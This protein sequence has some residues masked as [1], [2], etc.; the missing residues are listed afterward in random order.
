MRGVLPDG[1]E[2]AFIPNARD[3]IGGIRASGGQEAGDENQGKLEV[4]HGYSVDWV[5]FG[6]HNA[7]NQFDLRV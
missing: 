2:R 1:R 3:A 6:Q 5:H 4:F 7:I